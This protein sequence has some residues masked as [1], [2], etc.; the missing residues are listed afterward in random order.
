MNGIVGHVWAWIRGV[1]KPEHWRMRCARCGFTG[2]VHFPGF[3]PC[4]RFVP[5][6]A[7]VS[8]G[9]RYDRTTGRW[10]IR[11]GR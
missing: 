2:Q 1:H 3:F 10:Q 6:K 5:D 7:Y 11:S 8:P 9:L 4:R